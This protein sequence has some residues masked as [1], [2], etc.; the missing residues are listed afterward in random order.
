VRSPTSTR[1]TSSN[2][3]PYTP[4]PPVKK[5]SSSSASPVPSPPLAGNHFHS[6]PLVP[7]LHIDCWIL[8]INLLLDFYAGPKKL[9]LSQ[10]F[11]FIVISGVFLGLFFSRRK[12]ISRVSE[13][14]L[15]LCLTFYPQ[16]SVSSSAIIMCDSELQFIRRI[17]KYFKV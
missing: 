17:V 4:S 3:C 11:N 2:L 7:S 9:Q 10:N 5:S 13:V 12:Q 6:S 14:V 15:H 1:K 8:K 16:Y